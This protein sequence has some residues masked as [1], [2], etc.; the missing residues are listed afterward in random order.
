MTSLPLRLAAREFAA[1]RAS[2][3]LSAIAIAIPTTA[4]IVAQIVTSNR[5]P[6]GTGG[7][8]YDPSVQFG[9]CWRPAPS[10]SPSRSSSPSWWAPP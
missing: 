2:T 10:P 7:V 8:L 1:H 9:S 5:L 4:L 6:T 3:V